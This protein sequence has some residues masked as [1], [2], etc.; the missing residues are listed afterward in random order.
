TELTQGAVGYSATVGQSKL[1]IHTVALSAGTPSVQAVAVNENCYDGTCTTGRF[2]A[3][4]YSVQISGPNALGIHVLDALGSA[5]DPAQVASLNDAPYD[6]A[7]DNAGVV[8]AAI[9]R[10]MKQSYVVASSAQDGAAG[11][12]L[13]YGV[14]GT[15]AAR[16]IVFD[17]PEGTDGKSDVTTTVAG[18]RCQ[19]AITAGTTYDGHPLMFQVAA[20]ADGCTATEDLAV[21]PT[22]APAGG[23]ISPIGSP[24]VGGAGGST[25][26]TPAGS[27]TTAS[28]GSTAFGGTVGAAGTH[29][30]THGGTTAPAADSKSGCGCRLIPAQAT[31][32]TPILL[33]FAMLLTLARRRRNWAIGPLRR[34]SHRSG[35]RP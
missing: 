17:A 26:L 15:G 13:S 16:H 35:R 24:M 33:G 23:T 7:G 22:Q 12:T 18:D 10:S 11:A 3:Y 8:G 28:G 31:G 9:F 21:A 34:G 32:K 14:P 6:N 19:I 20:A 30:A 27:G 1:T 25:S 29:S 4:V 2:A 5:E